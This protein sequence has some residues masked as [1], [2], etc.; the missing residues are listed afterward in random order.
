MT[1][2]KPRKP[3]KPSQTTIAFD[4]VISELD[5]L[6]KRRQ[7]WEDGLQRAAN[8]E[9]YGILERCA[10]LYDRLLT[11]KTLIT[12]LGEA[13]RRLNVKQTAGSSLQVKVIRYVF[14]ECGQEFTYARVL[15]LAH[16]SK[17]TGMP[18][19]EWLAAEGGPSGVKKQKASKQQETQSLVRAAKLHFEAAPALSTLNS[20]PA[21]EPHSGA[22]HHFA[23]ALVRTN[24][25]G[26][27]EL[28]FGSNNM[29][30][31][32]HVLEIAAK[33]VPKDLRTQLLLQ[34][35]DNDD[36]ASDFTL[37]LTPIA[38]AGAAS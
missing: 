13:L 34:D 29:A 11:Q 19:T 24:A 10:D 28:V 9:L 18:F 27:T 25:E 14:G 12:K 3:R 38:A 7:T 33:S 5:K 20:V 32:N 4:S 2:K 23:V 6:S 37:T 15:K 36:D 22:D 26:R 31:T 17:P 21:L 30:L 8:D 35:A 16:D 1:I